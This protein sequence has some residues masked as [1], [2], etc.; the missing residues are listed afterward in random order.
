MRVPLTMGLVTAPPPKMTGLVGV[1]SLVVYI[2]QSV[3]NM[4]NLNHSLQSDFLFT[5]NY[6]HF[7][8]LKILYIRALM[9]KSFGN[10][11]KGKQIVSYVDFFQCS[12]L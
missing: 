2:Q 11:E 9:S 8:C 1:I 4:Q 12:V 10:C 5:L 3:N 7:L 6:L